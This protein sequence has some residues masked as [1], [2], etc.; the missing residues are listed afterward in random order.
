MSVSLFT[1][2][3]EQPFTWLVTIVIKLKNPSNFSCLKKTSFFPVIHSNLSPRDGRGLQ[4]QP[5]GLL[6][7][8][9]PVLEE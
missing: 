5:P 1:S 8:K 2:E 4:F 3:V 6:F 7:S 9:Q